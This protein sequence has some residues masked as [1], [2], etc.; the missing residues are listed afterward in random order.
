MGIA[1]RGA[2][3]PAFAVAGLDAAEKDAGGSRTPDRPSDSNHGS[4][5]L[6]IRRNSRYPM[7]E[8]FDAPDTRQTCAQLERGFKRHGHPQRPAAGAGKLI[9]DR[10]A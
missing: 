6:F 4:V 7:F 1:R 5:Y 8:A 10:L 2:I 9:Q 3:A